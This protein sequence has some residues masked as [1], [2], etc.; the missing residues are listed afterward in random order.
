MTEPLRVFIGVDRRQPV[1]LTVA[2]HSVAKNSSKPV[3]ITPLYLDQLPITRRGLTEFTYSRWLTP[4][5]A[6]FAGKALFMDADMIV[7]G[8]IAE[9]FEL[10]GMN[11]VSVMQLQERFEWASLML[12]NC[13]ACRML[14][15]E[16]VQ[17][18]KNKLFTLD[19]AP[20]VGRLPLEW[21]AIVG[22]NLDP[23]LTSAAKLLHYTRGIPVWEETQGNQ[24]DDYWFKEL[25]HANSTCSYD[26]LMAKSIHHERPRKQHEI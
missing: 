24:E 25:E 2:A 16:Y 7:R 4:W 23:I 6:G 26:D 19:W 20:Y 10:G 8:D 12:F 17:D 1:A 3:A 18:E 5:L 14:T 9:L 13:G 15:P 21:N 22:Y 11:A